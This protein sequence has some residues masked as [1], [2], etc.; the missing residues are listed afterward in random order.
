ME[1]RENDLSLLQDF[2][3]LN[4]QWITTYFEIEDADRALAA[5]P[6]KVIKEG[7][8]VFSLVSDA[9]EVLGVCALFNEGNSVY[10]LARMAVA[11]EHQGNGYAN[12]LMSACMNKLSLLGADRVYL[13]S[14]TKLTPAIGLYKKYGFTTVSEEQDPV[15]VRANIVMER[16][17]S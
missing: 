16:K 10:K 4:E 2:I 13:V 11:P 9:N 1:I 6:G 17:L 8:Y 5:N 7:G 3:R 12:M 14:N 15:Y